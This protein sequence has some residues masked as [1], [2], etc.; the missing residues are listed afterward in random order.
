MYGG[1]IVAVPLSIPVLGAM[2]VP[3][4][5]F[6]DTASHTMLVGLIVTRVG[7]FLNGC[8][9]GRPTERWFGVH[10][11]DHRGVWCRRIPAQVLDAAWAILVLAGAVALEESV[12]S[13]A[14]FLYTVAAYATGRV[15]LESTRQ[16][17]DWVFGF[18]L[19]R[20]VSLG[21][22]AASLVALGAAWR[23]H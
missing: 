18:S 15:F 8:C 16:D 3:F 2:G 13:G 6:W 22:V 5:A 7:C 10:L 23:T 1:L 21:L 14:L 19:Y 12:F 20:A 17:Q 11:A 9:A 4:G